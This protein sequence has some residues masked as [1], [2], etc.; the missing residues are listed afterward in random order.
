MLYLPALQ[1]RELITLWFSSFCS[2][3]NKIK[4][5]WINL[6]FLSLGRCFNLL[7]FPHADFLSPPGNR[8]LPSG[9]EALS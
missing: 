7:L 1:L 4:C 6:E 2:L 8:M 9:Y 3:K 5:S